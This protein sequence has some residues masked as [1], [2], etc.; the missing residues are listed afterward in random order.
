MLIKIVK[1][2]SQETSSSNIHF[3]ELNFSKD[4]QTEPASS[5]IVVKYL[6]PNEVSRFIGKHEAKFY[7]IVA[8]MIGEMP[9]PICYDGSADGSRGCTVKKLALSLPFPPFARALRP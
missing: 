3:L 6:K 8:E 7:R 4:A 1:K 2:R 9:I 5:K